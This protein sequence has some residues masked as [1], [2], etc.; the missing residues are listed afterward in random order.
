M[1]KERRSGQGPVWVGG[2]GRQR[3]ASEECPVSYVTGASLA[4]LEEFCAYR[5]LGRPADIERW[6]AK[7]VEALAALAA[8]EEQWQRSSRN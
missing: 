4:W 1:A 3:V 6:P 2:D 8:E 5:A 7:R